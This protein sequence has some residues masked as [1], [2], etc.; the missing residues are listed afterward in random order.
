[1]QGTSAIQTTEATAPVLYVLVD[2]N[3]GIRSQDLRSLQSYESKTTYP[4]GNLDRPIKV[5][6][7]V[8]AS[9]A[10]EV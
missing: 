10:Q 7:R 3:G 2:R 6:R 1:M 4:L 5:T 9:D 8:W